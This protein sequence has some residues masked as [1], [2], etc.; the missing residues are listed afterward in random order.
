[1]NV[2]NTPASILFLIVSPFISARHILFTLRG[3]FYVDDF[4]FSFLK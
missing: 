2:P 4:S 1:M 3:Y